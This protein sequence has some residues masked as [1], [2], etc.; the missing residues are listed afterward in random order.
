MNKR[1]FP[2]KFVSQKEEEK[3]YMQQETAIFKVFNNLLAKAKTLLPFPW[4]VKSHDD[5]SWLHWVF[6]FQ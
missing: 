2:C 6:Q 3:C 1:L 5:H 4:P